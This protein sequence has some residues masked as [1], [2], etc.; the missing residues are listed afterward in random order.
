MASED[1]ELGRVLRF[2]DGDDRRPGAEVRLDRLERTVVSHIEEANTVRD[3]VRVLDA[4]LQGYPLLDKGVAQRVAD[5][6]ERDDEAREGRSMFLGFLRERTMLLGFG[7]VQ[8]LIL[9]WV[10][11]R[12]GG[13]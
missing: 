7:V 10:A 4:H 8:T 13:Q 1:R 5:H 6:I 11:L 12:I 3:R 9:A 2:V